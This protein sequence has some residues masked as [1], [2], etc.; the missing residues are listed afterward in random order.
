[1]NSRLFIILIF[2]LLLF[3][4]ARTEDPHYIFFHSHVEDLAGL[5]TSEQHDSL[6]LILDKIE[7]ETTNQIVI[8]II[9]D[10]EGLKIEVF[11]IELA[12]RSRI[13]QKIKNNGI[14]ILCAMQARQIRI[15]VGYG[16]EPI[17]TDAVASSIIDKSI[18][19]HFR[20][21]DFYTGFYEGIKALKSYLYQED[22][23]QYFS[24]KWDIP[25]FENFIKKH[26]GSVMKCDA[27]MYLGRFFEDKWQDKI[28][29]VFGEDE[30]QNSIKYYQQYLIECPNGIR[31]QLVEYELSLVSAK[32]P[33]SKKYLISE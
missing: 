7:Q 12:E 33:D 19:P 8:A 13:G 1:M 15:E 3:N 24:I 16:L 29:K 21:S 4:K 25:S 9:N 32:K 31:R 23:Y 5:L 2:T 27:L 28:L 17:I 20:K 26:S 11:S 10:L 22:V 18:V 30:R 14:L 6:N